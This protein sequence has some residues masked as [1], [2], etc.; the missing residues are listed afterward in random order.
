MN[1]G[2]DEYGNRVQN[3]EDSHSSEDDQPLATNGRDN[4]RSSSSSSSGSEF[5][6]DTQIIIGE[7]GNQSIQEPLVNAADVL[8]SATAAAAPDGSTFLLENRFA[9][10]T[11]A[12]ANA[13][14]L[15]LTDG[16]RPIETP[17]SFYDVLSGVPSRVCSICLLGALHHGKTS[18]LSLLLQAG[19]VTDDDR[20]RPSET[21]KRG[22]TKRR[23]KLEAP[24]EALPCA[25]PRRLDEVEQGLSIKTHVL[26]SL[27]RGAEAHAAA[28]WCTFLDT[29]GHPQLLGEAAAALRLADAALL[30]VDA[31]EGISLATEALVR[32]A[33]LL[34]E[35]PLVLVITKMDRLILDLKLPPQDA[36]RKLR[37]LIDTLNNLIVS[38]GGAQASRRLVSPENGTVCFSSAQL[39][40]F[41]PRDVRKEVRR[42]VPDTRHGSLCAEAMGPGTLREGCFGKITNIRQ[43]PT[44]V[45]FVL[46]P[47]YKIVAHAVTGKGHESLTTGLKP[48]P[49]SPLSAAREAVQ[50]FLGEAAGEGMDALLSVLPRSL[51]RLP[52]LR[53]QYGATA[54]G[55]SPTEGLDGAPHSTT[56]C[57][58]SP[59]L[60]RFREEEPAAVVRVLQGELRPG[61]PLV[62]RD[63]YTSDMDPY[64]TIQVSGVYTRTVEK[65]YVPLQHARAGQ[66]V[67]VTGLPARAGSHLLLVAD[68]VAPLLRAGTNVEE[69]DEDE[70]ARQRVDALRLHPFLRAE[71][72]VHVSLELKEP[73]AAARVEASAQTLLRTSP[74]VDI[75]KEETGEYTFS[76][77]GEL[78]LNAVLRELRQDLCAGVALGLSQP[79]VSFSETVLEAEGALA[80]VGGRP[81]EALGF[82]S[83]AMDAGLAEAVAYERLDLPSLVAPAAGPAAHTVR[84]WTT[85]RK[86]Y[87]MDALDAQHI[88]AA[89]PD[90]TKGPS[91]LIDDTLPEEVQF[92]PLSTR[93]RQAVVAGFRS[94]LAA[95]P[96]IGEL[97]RATQVKLIFADVEHASTR[98]AVILGH[99][100]SGVKE[101]LLGAR[102]RLLEPVFR[103]EVLCTAEEVEK[104]TEI[105][106]SRRGA[107]VGEEPIP[108]T[109]L[110]RLRAMVPAIETFGLEAQIRMMTHGQAFPC[111]EF[112]RWDLVPGDPYDASIRLGPL[113]PAKGHQLARDFV[114]KTRFRKGLAPL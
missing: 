102:P 88:I 4:R 83:G 91:I 35:M 94:A 16:R 110:L 103:I 108:A 18:V 48:L 73:S 66:V 98:D 69:G 62:V 50:L 101:A 86:Q 114:A 54:L 9:A 26:A 90:K 63:N 81:T 25:Y 27:A 68:A 36:Y 33:V 30:C 105:V 43:K 61:T 100:R 57:A 72:H 87:H 15:R 59:L 34:E 7:T 75:R 6:D 3:E 55:E 5:G 42:R 93:H 84:L 58:I 92:A 70:D 38:F 64:Y 111:Y 77:A 11:G 22:A 52:W 21:G 99:A 19:A 24:A 112:A 89:G 41:L 56:V 85:L 10:S 20:A 71:A 60:R 28:H 76:G 51:S 47:L 23:P 53:E 109:V 113:E 65:G 46:E 14:L 96:L 44:F 82:V 80:T 8:P 12:S 97:V 31:V 79:F 37:H 107:I 32:Q 74:G 104:V 40:F 95:G 49:R 1:F 17:G 39:S 106:R 29:P 45:A 13:P 67:Y 2:Y 78:H